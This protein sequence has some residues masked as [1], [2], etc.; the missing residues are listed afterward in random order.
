MSITSSPINQ[1]MKAVIL[2]VLILAIA[3]CG[4]K[5]WNKEY[6]ET[7]C[8]KEF[9]K[10]NAKEKLFTDEQL[11]TLCDCVAGK[12]VTQYKSEAEADKDAAGSSEIGRECA[13]QV[14][15]PGAE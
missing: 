5:E 7:K 11:K 12:M 3:G 9:T 10:K 1:F 6:L 2:S 13:M 8:N 15:S 14:M 4:K